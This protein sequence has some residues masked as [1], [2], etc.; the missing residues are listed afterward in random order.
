MTKI[1]YRLMNI[2]CIEGDHLILPL[3]MLEGYLDFQHQYS[4]EVCQA[5]ELQKANSQTILL[6]TK[7]DLMIL[8]VGLNPMIVELMDCYIKSIRII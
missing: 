1:S 2:S 3:H 8:L 5:L 4:L 7:L 6:A